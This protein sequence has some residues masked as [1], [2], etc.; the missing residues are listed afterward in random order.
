MGY[1]IKIVYPDGSAHI[2]KEVYKTKAGAEKKA[3][4]F[5]D[6]LKPEVRVVQVG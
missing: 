5:R 1:K 2:R 3:K 4:W 6:H